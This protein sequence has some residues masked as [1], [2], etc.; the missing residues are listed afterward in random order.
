MGKLEGL[1]YIILPEKADPESLGIKWLG[2]KDSNLDSRS[3][4]PLSYR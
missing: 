4:S 2:D 3:Q 1:D